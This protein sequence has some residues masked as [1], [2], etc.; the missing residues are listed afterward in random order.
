MSV[1]LFENIL[2]LTRPTHMNTRIKARI[3]QGLF[4]LIVF[5]IT[6]FIGDYFLPTDLL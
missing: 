4:N 5:L 1:N 6:W 2:H 3:Y